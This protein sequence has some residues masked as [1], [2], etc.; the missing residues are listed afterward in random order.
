LVSVNEPAARTARGLAAFRSWLRRSGIQSDEG[1]FYDWYELDTESPGR[2]YPEITGYGISTLVWLYHQDRDDDLLERATTAARWLVSQALHPSYDMVFARGTARDAG[3]GC[4]TPNLYAFD[5]GI[6]GAGLTRLGAITEEATWTV[7]AERIAHALSTRMKRTDGRLWPLLDP[8]T[9]TPV[10]ADDAW[11]SRFSGYQAKA[12]SFLN[13]DG[14]SGGYALLGEVVRKTLEEQRDSGAFPSYVDGQ[15]HLHPHLYALEGLLSSRSAPGLPPVDDAVL[16][17]YLYA[18]RLLAANGCLPTLAHDD[19]VSA[20]YE[21]ADALAQFLRLGCLLISR[22]WLS[23]DR[24][25]GILGGAASRLL[26]YQVEEPPHKGGFLFGRDADG[27]AKRHV[28]SHTGFFAGQALH[29]FGLVR[30]GARPDL[31]ELV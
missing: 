14:L 5:T 29:W 3:R 20:A 23:R 22:G 8:R 6:A 4:K 21:R 19:H 10:T 26:D 17:G 16:R 25:D 1:F 12:V 9:G 13:L 7:S 28:T 11:S 30:D 31:G 2:P 27:T 24:L 18:E 15:V